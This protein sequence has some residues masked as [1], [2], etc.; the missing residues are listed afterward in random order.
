MSTE[1]KTDVTAASVGGGASGSVQWWVADLDRYGNPT[2]TDGA[3]SER[4]GCEQ[5][6]Y[7]MRRLGLRPEQRR[8]IC[9][10]EIY[11]PE[12]KSH[13]ANEDALN[14]L[15]GIGLGQNVQDHRSLREAI[16]PKNETNGK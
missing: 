12:A 4:E 9:R 8:A 10:V 16:Q 3:H 13:G 5:A 2:L 7:I 1:S 14:T 15:N 11:P 6:L